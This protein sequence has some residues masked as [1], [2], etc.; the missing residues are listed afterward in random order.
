[1]NIGI[2]GNE[3]NVLNRVGVNKYALK[4]LWHM[5]E[6]NQK[7]PKPDNLIV[8][9]KSEPL[10]DLPKQNKYFKYKIIQGGPLWILTRLNPYL[11]VNPDDLDVFFTPSHYIPLFLTMPRIC[12]IMDLGY[13]ENTTHFEKKVL[14][15]LKYW[16]ASSI[17]FAKRVLTISE[18]SKSDIVRHYPWSEQKIVVTPLSHDLAK[19][20]FTVSMTE[21]QRLKD[22][23]SIVDDYILYVG[24]L[25]PSKNI[26]GIIKGFNYYILQS[27]DKKTKLVIVG[28]KGWMYQDLFK[29]VSKLKLTNRVVFTDF[30]EE[31][32]KMIL[33]KGAKIFMQPSHWEGFGIDTLSAMV[34]GVPVIASKVG[35]LPEIVGDNGLLVDNLDYKD[36]GRKIIKLMNMEIKEYQKVVKYQKDR[37]KRFSWTSCAKKTMEVLRLK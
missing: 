3:A 30:V 19:E 16:T 34:I 36:I 29:L 12:S 27:G 8:Y 1:M 37:A 26:D 4:L 15:Q 10:S 11:L 35:S 9:L 23:Y 20:D 5:D 33:R 7:S 28:K 32:E 6:V 22:R 25:K 18:A 21:V 24:T 14:W 17:F 31:K 13:L 2:D